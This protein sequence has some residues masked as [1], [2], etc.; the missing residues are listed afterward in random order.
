VK[1]G[2][3]TSRLQALSDWLGAGLG[4]DVRFDKTVKFDLRG[5]GFIFIDGVTITHEDRPADLT[6]TV[7]IDDL[8][9]IGQGKLSTIGAVASRRLGLSDMGVA[10]S[11]LVPLRALFARSAQAAGSR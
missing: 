10:T 6:A 7:S 11:L 9:A 2:P 8:R 5:E 1:S 3:E 4:G